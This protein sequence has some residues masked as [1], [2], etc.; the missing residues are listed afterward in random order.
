MSHTENFV[1]ES[2]TVEPPPPPSW[3]LRSRRLTNPEPIHSTPPAQP[4]QSAPLP[5]Q[6]PSKSPPPINEDATEPPN[7]SS[8]RRLLKHLTSAYGLSLV[9]HAIVL[10]GMWLIVMPQDTKDLLLN[11]LITNHEQPVED[12]TFE[13]IEQPPELA[14]PQI[15]T[16]TD[17]A[18]ELTNLVSEEP[19]TN[20]LDISDLE[21]SLDLNPDAF[22]GPPVANIKNQREG[23]SQ[24]NRDQMLSKRGGNQASDA[25]VASGLKWLASVQQADGSWNFAEIG[26][27]SQPGRLR[28]G[29]NGATAMALMTFLGAGHTHT[30]PGPYQQ[31]VKQGIDFLRV[32][33]VSNRGPDGWDFRGENVGNAG[34]YIQGMVTIALCE[35]YGM[36]KDRLLR[37][38][39][40]GAIQ[41]IVKA[42]DPAGGG[43]RY[44]LQQAGD[45]SV[46][47]WEIM[48]LKS[49]HQAGLEVP[50]H[51]ISGARKFLDRVASNGGSRY[52]YVPGQR[53]KPSTTAIGLLCRMYL[54]WDREDKALG[55][56]V[57]YLVSTEPATN[58]M[59]Y[60]YYAT[61][62]IIQFTNAQGDDWQ[63]WN[64]RMRDW[65]VK[66][67]RTSG[68][69]KG[70]WNVADTHG[71]QGGRLY[72]TCLA[73]MTLEVYYRVL[74]IYK[75]DASQKNF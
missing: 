75:N 25:A 43:W 70:S 19:D 1:E 58:D 30:E 28:N 45:T 61:Q 23:R 50:R 67:Q 26:K 15:D 71:S 17:L 6:E 52:S 44:Q 59:Y 62:S 49:G 72:M 21:A 27:S 33:F 10:L 18:P 64:G 41:F 36:T 46:V 4:P 35:A 73:V 34:M 57:R 22:A 16:N 37:R 63:K 53:P 11:L 74:P 42:Q 24:A 14:P 47:G 2:A 56:G 7:P 51:V 48:A 3:L 66:T 60:N 13:A 68:P 69:E 9:L 65:L 54:G 29:E 8:Y 55:D 5:T 20:Q 12:L 38:P 31:T 32:N 40:E 39:A